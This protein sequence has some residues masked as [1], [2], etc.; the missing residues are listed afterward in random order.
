MEQ[1][2]YHMILNKKG[3][4]MLLAAHNYLCRSSQNPIISFMYSILYLNS[5]LAQCLCAT[6]KFAMRISLKTRNIKLNKYVK[7]KTVKRWFE[8]RRKAQ[9]LSQHFLRYFT[10]ITVRRHCEENLPNKPAN[11][12]NTKLILSLLL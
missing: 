5:L 10:N 8:F 9:C 6:K 2:P 12:S 11:T 1:L 3:M 7:L 4:R